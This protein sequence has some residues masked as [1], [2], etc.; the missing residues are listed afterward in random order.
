M[1]WKAFK[2]YPKAF[3]HRNTIAFMAS[4]RAKT[5]IGKL[6]SSMLVYLI[7]EILIIAGSW[8]GLLPRLSRRVAGT[9]NVAGI[10]VYLVVLAIGLALGI[11]GLLFM[12]SGFKI[13]QKSNER[14]SIGTTG[15]LVEIIGAIIVGVAIVFL[16]AGVASAGSITTMGHQAGAA[17]NILG[18]II[19]LVVG[20]IT[21]FVGAILAMIGF[22][23]VGEA[24][25]S[26]TIK[27]GAILYLIITIVGVILLFIGLWDIESKG[28]K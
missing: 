21:V 27:V 19:L 3:I 23:R 2:G 16:I 18:A 22:F 4:P 24:Y 9:P 8:S 15:T 11:V 12:R 17:L 26:D 10:I 13:L 14:Y 5:G 25:R 6:R 7:A 20:G 28:R 1:H